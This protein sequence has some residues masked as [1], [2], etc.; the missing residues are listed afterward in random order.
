MLLILET[1]KATKRWNHWFRTFETYLKIVESSKPDKLETLIYF[2]DPLVYDHIADHTDYESAIDTLRKLYVRPKNVI[3]ARYLLQTYKQ[4]N[5]QEIDHFV[6][7]LKSLAKFCEFKSVS[8]TDYKD[9]CVRDA[10]ING[11][12]TISIR[13][14][15]L[16]QSELTLDQAYQLVRPIELAHKQSQAYVSNEPISCSTIPPISQDRELPVDLTTAAVKS[17][18]TCYFCGY[19]THPRPKCPI[20]E[21]VCNLCGKRGHFRRVCRSK[22]TT[23]FH[24]SRTAKP[25]LSSLFVAAAATC[26]AHNIV[27]IEV[28]GI[29]LRALV[30]TGSSCSFIN[31]K[32]VKMHNWKIYPTFSVVTMAPTSLSCRTTGYVCVS[33]RYR[34]TSYNELKLFVM[35]NLCTDVLLGHDFLGLH[36]ITKCRLESKLN[37]QWDFRSLVIS[38]LI[39][40]LSGIAEDQRLHAAREFDADMSETLS[41]PPKHLKLNRTG[42]GDDYSN[43]S[44][45]C[46]YSTKS[47]NQQ[48]LKQNVSSRFQ[49][50]VML[51]DWRVNRSTQPG[52]ICTQLKQSSFIIRTLSIDSKYTTQVRFYRTYMSNCG[53]H[54]TPPGTAVYR[55]CASTTNKH[56]LPHRPEFII[57]IDSMTSVFNANASLPQNH[58]L[59][60]S[61]IV[62]KRT[63]VDAEGT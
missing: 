36:N 60:K 55:A 23:E 63:K 27:T 43:E 8:A 42:Q 12:A 24:T 31:S 15:L 33:V 7:K 51:P 59:F 46:M 3:Y 44:R 61:L 47:C 48:H 37:L 28:N 20:R 19:D 11:L 54:I 34:D 32:V 62:K 38:R 53:V 35:P 6:R 1:A 26:L 30:D 39:T 17:T 45:V 52:M 50:S 41:E 22:N 56:R 40:H 16:A 4:E 14:K 10:I 5:G 21:D 29:A 9:E 25:N 58:D 2:V 18:H 49:T 13:E 57:I